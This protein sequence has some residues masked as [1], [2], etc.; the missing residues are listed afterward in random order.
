M[1]QTMR[2]ALI[3][4]GAIGKLRAEAMLQ[5]PGAKLAVVSDT[6]EGHGQE[7]ASS[8]GARF[9][10]DWRQVVETE[11]E[12]VIVSTPPPLHLEMVTGAVERGKHV[13]CEKP[14][15]RYPDECRQMVAAAEKAGRYLGTGFNYRFYQAIVSAK[16][17]LDSGRIG[18]LDHVRSFAG[19]PGGKEFTHPWVHDVTI[20]GGGALLDNGIHILDLTQF[21]L[22]DVAEV[23]GYR[24][25]H[26]WKFPE[27]E[28]NAFALLKNRQGKTATV[29][30]SWSEWRGYRFRIEVYGTLGCV[31]A[32]Y[33]PMFAEAIWFDR[34]DG[35]RRRQFFTYPMFQVIERMKSYK[36]TVVQSFIAEVQAFMRAARGEKVSAATGFEGMRAV[37][38]A[39]GV[40][41]SS[42]TGETVKLNGERRTQNAELETS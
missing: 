15:G 31:R 13:L 17:V 38:I 33:P 3:G 21:F 11:V 14:L 1:S 12:A 8:S 35:K 40:Y 32:L 9:E 16:E 30:A 22:G 7:L 10:R 18:E 4:C 39:H 36:Y 5:T 2:F 27:T 23:K 26:V 25:G 34:P 20:M 41:R 24:S 29:Q 42:A 6:D 37:E 28:D 19:H